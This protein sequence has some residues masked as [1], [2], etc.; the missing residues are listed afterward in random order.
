MWLTDLFNKIFPLLSISP[1]PNELEKQYQLRMQEHR[2]KMFNRGLLVSKIRKEVDSALEDYL[3]DPT[4][5]AADNFT[6]RMERFILELLKL[7]VG[8]ML[9]EM[10][11]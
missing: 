2:T 10:D 6:F 1:H 5:E 9:K 11:F 4:P 8:S 7:D 3:L